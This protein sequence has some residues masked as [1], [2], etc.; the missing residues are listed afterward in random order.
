ML[1][2]YTCSYGTLF[3]TVLGVNQSLEMI[4][5]STALKAYLC[6][7]LGPQTAALGSSEGVLKMSWRNEVS[8]L[9]R[10]AATISQPL[11]QAP[12]APAR[13]VFPLGP[14]GRWGS[15]VLRMLELSRKARYTWRHLKLMFYCHGPCL[16][17]EI[18]L[19]LRSWDGS[20]GAQTIFLSPQLLKQKSRP[21]VTTPVVVDNGSG[22]R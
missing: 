16:M 5:S 10:A 18:R 2:S 1:L 8:F 12:V 4:L 3:L 9:F 20:G 17:L 21:D 14:S 13:K 15:R 19:C 11:R 7:H 6:A 22:T